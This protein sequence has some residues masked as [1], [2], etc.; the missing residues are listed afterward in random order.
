MPKDKKN[1]NTSS[2]RHFTLIELLVVIAIIAI[3]AA[4]LL[5]ALNG[6]REKA[7]AISCA[8][9][10]K[11]LGLA[12][13]LYAD[14]YKEYLP[15]FGQPNWYQMIAPYAGLKTFHS[16][17]QINGVFCCPSY[18][19]KTTVA[20]RAAA[21]W[22]TYRPTR[23][24]S[25]KATPQKSGSA[26]YGWGT[27]INGTQG[28][29]VAKKTTHVWEKSIIL[30]ET[31]PDQVNGL[32]TGT[33]AYTGVPNA[34]AYGP[35]YNPGGSFMIYFWHQRSFNFLHMGGHVKSWRRGTRF[36][37]NSAD[38]DMDWNPDNVR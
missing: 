17:E 10:M 5:P 19:R 23:P 24:L 30:A 3:L 4:M 7:R 14:D 8:S 9:K 35:D 28:R 34:T 26:T 6:A 25:D 13:Y 12:T 37:R 29:Y 2:L 31:V 15:S 18:E 21:S 27:T 33:G 32:F 36:C 11:Q 1:F 22:I 20:N 16:H 38:N